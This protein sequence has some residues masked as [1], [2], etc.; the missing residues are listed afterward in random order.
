MYDQNIL[1]IKR[2]LWLRAPGVGLR[3][4]SLS[5]TCHENHLAGL[6]EPDKMAVA[7]N[8]GSDSWVSFKEEPDYFGVYTG[9]I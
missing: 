4:R 2:G 3:V 7:T 8:W 9:P 1:Q 5:L 6:A